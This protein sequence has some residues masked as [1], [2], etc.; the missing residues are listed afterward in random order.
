MRNTRRIPKRSPRRPP[1]TISAASGR[2]LAVI[3]HCDS[4]IEACSPSIACGAAS[5]TAVWST[6]IIEL[7][8]V[9]A[10]SVRR[11][12]R[13]EVMS[14]RQPIRAAGRLPG[15]LVGDLG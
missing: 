5:G 8:S 9:I 2:M 11:M 12:F 13:R 4:L 7:D 15:K 10:T 1:K 6:R 3:S 14:R